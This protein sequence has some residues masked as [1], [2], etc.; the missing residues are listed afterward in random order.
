M[1]KRDSVT[2]L[3]RMIGGARRHAVALVALFVALGASSYA[4]VSSSRFVSPGGKVSACV[5]DRSGAV[6]LVSAHTRCRRGE[7]AVT[8][9]QQGPAGTAG[10]PGPQGAT[11]AAGASGPAG[12]TGSAG[13]S[14]T[15]TTLTSG[16]SN[17]PAGGSR[18]TSASGVTFAC[19]GAPASLTTTAGPTQSGIL[20]GTTIFPAIVLQNLGRVQLTP[21]LEIHSGPTPFTATCFAEVTT[22]VDGVSRV[23]PTQSVS[24]AASTTSDYD[25]VVVVDGGGAGDSI[26]VI[27]S[28][29]SSTASLGTTIT[30]SVTAIT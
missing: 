18:F 8:W 12:T 17:C 19:N 28:C 16:D 15:S 22:G 21:Q 6:R 20:I 10:K 13:A 3:G 7:S 5:G 1:G 9:N 14:V 26:S 25:S 29:T 2:V 23:L 30:P 24:A 11:G 4:A 27:F